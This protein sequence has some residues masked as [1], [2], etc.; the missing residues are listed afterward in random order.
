MIW[1]IAAYYLGAV[2][3]L[4]ALAIFAYRNG[5][6]LGFGAMIAV[7]VW[8]L[9]WPVIIFQSLIDPDEDQGGRR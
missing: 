9:F 4:I 3:S 7:G 8:P 5:C 1:W 6:I 2:L